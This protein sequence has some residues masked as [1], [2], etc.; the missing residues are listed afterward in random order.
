MVSFCDV[1]AVLLLLVILVL[2]VPK[3]INSEKKSGM[4]VF[5]VDKAMDQPIPNLTKP[6]EYNWRGF[7]AG[8]PYAILNLQLDGVRGEYG[9]SLG[10]QSKFANGGL[11]SFY[12]SGQFMR[13]RDYE[14]L[15]RAAWFDDPSI[16]GLALGCGAPSGSKL[17]PPTGPA[18]V[19]PGDA[20]KAMSQKKEGFEVA[21]TINDE[22]E[23]SDAAAIGAAETAATIGM[24]TCREDVNADS[25]DYNSYMRSLVADDRMLANQAAW[26]KEVQP[27]SQTSLIIKDFDIEP[28]V[29]FQGLRRPQAVAV[30]N[31]TQLTELAP[32]DL[33]PN[34]KFDF[35]G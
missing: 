12:R 24:R 18:P 20:E 32:E 35:Q 7:T 5:E 22:S 14:L 15:N 16:K 17:I 29:S 21:G 10:R 1:L 9:P 11:A 33:A 6:S 26:V 19:Q 27:F 4:S 2:A 23:I 25:T 34:K 3:Y 13:P 30:Y 28:Y 8:D 31:P